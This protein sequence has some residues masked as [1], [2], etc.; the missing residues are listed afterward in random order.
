MFFAASKILGC[1]ALPSNL[2]ISLMVLG[3]VLQWTRF[4]RIGYRLLLASLAALVV[5]GLSPL[6]FVMVHAL[7]SRF[8]SWDVSRGAPAG[9]VILGGA[10]DP[11]LSAAHATPALDATAERITAVAELA[12]R[13]PAAKFV[14][15]GG[16]GSLFGGPSEADYVASLF[17]SFG[18]APD[19][20]RLERRSR[21]TQENAVFSKELVRPA[22]GEHW[23]IVTSAVHMPRAIGAF[24]AAGFDVEA[25][26]VDWRTAGGAQLFAPVA[27]LVL[28]LRATDAAVHEIVGLVAYWLTGR[29]SELF[30]APR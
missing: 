8:P 7:E 16:N 24:R 17:Q 21:N 19:R 15:S 13:Y 23:V 5:F 1:F 26:P 28:G 20:V 25:Y 6:G 10:V 11:E 29:S 2:L 22:V 30:P 4:A 18:I 9:F 12:R 27:S 14:Y 3:T